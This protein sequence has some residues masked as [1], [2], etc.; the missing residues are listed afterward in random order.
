MSVQTVLIDFSIDAARVADKQAQKDLL[1]LVKVGLDKYFTQLKFV[2]DVQTDDGSLSMFSDRNLTVIS[3]RFFTVGLLTVNIEYYKRDD[4]APAFTFD[5][6]VRV[7]VCG[8][9]TYIAFQWIKSFK[10]N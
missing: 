4:E 10:K 7:C 2:C 3:V 8:L 1:K 5:V 6:S 9:L